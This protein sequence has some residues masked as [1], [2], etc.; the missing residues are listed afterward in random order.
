MTDPSFESSTLLPPFNWQLDSEFAEF[1]PAQ[2]ALQ[3]FYRGRGRAVFASQ[4][5]RLSPGSYVFRTAIDSVP[6]ST[7]G[8]FVWQ[9]V[10]L[11]SD[12]FP[13][14]ISIFDYA[15]LEDDDAVTFEISDACAYQELSIRGY[16]GQFTRNATLQINDIEIVA[17]EQAP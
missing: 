13:L 1:M 4:I 2:A 11:T 6:D 8:D 5:T 7:G 10:C 3:I 14:E 9:L 16:P 12:E 15:A 17:M